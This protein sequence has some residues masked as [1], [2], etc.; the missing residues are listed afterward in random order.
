MGAPT[1]VVARKE[2]D[3]IEELLQRVYAKCIEDAECMNWTGA[4]QSQCKSPCMR[5]VASRGHC[6]SLRRMMIEVSTGKKIEGTKVAT[7]TC[8]N[9]RC[10]RLEHL[11][12]ITRKALQER[13][14]S[15]L[16][17]VQRLRKSRKISEKAR[18]RGKLTVELAQEIAAAEGSQRDLARKYGISQS[19]VGMVRRR[20]TWR[21]LTNPFARLA[22]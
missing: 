20:E 14:D 5:P 17:A 15:K 16:D 6:V 7:Y 13:N 12:V 21:D 2:Q 10:V 8:G 11:G 19:T 3:M 1:K 4:V 22:A 9:V 18:A